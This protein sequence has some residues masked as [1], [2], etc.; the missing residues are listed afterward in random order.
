MKRV[1]VFLFLLGIM[2]SS[3][4]A[5]E[6][7][8]S[9]SLVGGETLSDALMLRMSLDTLFV[10]H[11][12][13]ERPVAV[14]DISVIYR[15][16]GEGN[17]SVGLLAGVTFGGAAGFVTS[18]LLR[19]RTNST[20]EE[21][22]SLIGPLAG[23]ALGGIVGSLVGESSSV[24]TYE[25][26]RLSKS[27]KA[28]VLRVLLAEDSG[29]PTTAL[30]P[31]EE[32]M[33]PV[34][35][36][37][38][39][40]S[41]RRSGG[42]NLFTFHVGPSVPAGEF[43]SNSGLGSGLAKLGFFFGGD[44]TVPVS[45]IVA[46]HLSALASFNSVDLS[47]GENRSGFAVTPG[48]WF[49]LW[50]TTG[51]TLFQQVSSEIEVSYSLHFGALYG[52]SPETIIDEPARKTVTGSSSA[53]SV[54]YGAGVEIVFDRTIALSARYLRGSPDY[55]IT[56]TRGT[57]STATKLHFPTSMLLVSLGLVF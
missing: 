6:G 34:A 17:L 29:E 40:R 20:E 19:M 8:W 55:E 54:S 50:P 25:L 3:T 23:V 11:H 49:N 38:M 44:L 37:W 51:I 47:D 41:A 12:L 9:F 45:D 36:D 21:S 14:K 26:F 27:Q 46:W 24:E 4:R 15:R 2:E 32:D 1:V 22:R 35:R 48:H 16:V 52:I 56:T 31:D 53:S 7:G 57:V 33:E 13:V 10:R 5:Q 43:G 30:G 42:R 39:E 18:E 28:I